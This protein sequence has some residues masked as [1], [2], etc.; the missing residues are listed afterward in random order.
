M[1]PDGIC[2]CFYNNISYKMKIWTDQPIKNAVTSGF[3]LDKSDYDQSISNCLI[4]GAPFQWSM[5]SDC[6]NLT[7]ISPL[8]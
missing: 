6:K 4:E 3:I 2:A 1:A 8:N 5:K 7:M